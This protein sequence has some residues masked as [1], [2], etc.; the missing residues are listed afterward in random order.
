MLAQVA[1]DSAKRQFDIDIMEEIRLIRSAMDITKYKYPKFW[2]SIKPGFSRSHINNKLI[3]PMNYLYDLKSDKIRSTEETLP[4][5]YFF[6]RYPLEKDKQACKKVEE[7]ISKYS[8]DLYST[9]KDTDEA[10]EDYILLRKDFD[11]MIEDIRKT[12]ISN[13]YI[14]LISWLLDRAFKIT[15]R[16]QANSDE[17]NSTI[18]KNKSVLLKILYQINPKAILRCFSGNMN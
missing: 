16:V 7:L 14:G 10:Y 18:D 17:L 1:I 12:Y 9:Q 5:S 8:W 2:A 11:K 3:C 15:P 4:M 6:V 13:N